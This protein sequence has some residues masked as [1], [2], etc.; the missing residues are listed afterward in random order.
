MKISR[1]F[2]KRQEQVIKKSKFLLR[3][4][5]VI[6]VTTFVVLFFIGVFMF[7]SFGSSTQ[8]AN[9]ARIVSVFNEGKKRTVTTRAKSVGELLERLDVELV[10]EDLIEPSR[11]TPILEDNTHVNIYKARSVQ[12]VDGDRVLTVFTAQRAPRL[13]AADAGV[14]LLPEDEA[15]FEPVES[16][17]L[18]SAATEQ[19]TIYRSV[20]V[21]LNLYGVVKEIRSTALTVQDLL[22]EGKIM[23]SDGET[24]QPD[25]E[26]SI[27]SGMLVSVNRPGVKALAVSEPIPFEILT[28]DDA[29]IQ[30]GKTQIEQ[31]GVEGEK[32]VIYEITEDDQGNEISRQQIQ[33]VTLKQPVNRIVLRGTKIIAP[34]FD[35]GTSVSADKVAL[36]SAAGIAASDYGFVDFIVQHESNWRPGAVNSSS[37][38]YGLCQSLPASKMASAGADYLTNPVTQLRWCSGYATGR[39][40]SW[41]GAYGA[42]LAQGWW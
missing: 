32:A 14:K 5:L 39:Y 29:S 38:A 25:L 36:M 2:K 8:G 34:R 20:E 19:L 6:P 16:S 18:E 4:P 27:E 9:D 26:S 12:L 17:K 24:V 10:E 31:E 15:K 37:G 41:A 7:I 3:H 35:S 1:K 23:P 40:G 28:K 11:E 22:E 13:V 30:A 33:V 21:K 42:W